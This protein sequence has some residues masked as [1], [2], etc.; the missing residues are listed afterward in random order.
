MPVTRR[1]TTRVPEIPTPW[2]AAY[3]LKRSGITMPPKVPMTTQDRAYTSRIQ[4][5]P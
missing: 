2:W 1:C 5:A 3:E 4:Y